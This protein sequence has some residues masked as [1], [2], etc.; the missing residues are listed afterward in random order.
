MINTGASNIEKELS[1]KGIVLIDDINSTNKEL[2][3]NII[4]NCDLYI[5][6]GFPKPSTNAAIVIKL[7]TTMSKINTLLEETKNTRPDIFLS[8]T[9]FNNFKQKVNFWNTGLFKD[10]IEKLDS[11]TPNINVVINNKIK[12]HDWVYINVLKKLGVNFLVIS[13]KEPFMQNAEIDKEI[14]YKT[15]ENI[16]YVVRD[17]ENNEYTKREIISAKEFKSIDD[18]ESALYDKNETVKVIVSGIGNYNDTCNFYGRLHI[19][20]DKNSRRYKLY[21]G[22]LYSI[23]PDETD[24]IPRVANMNSSYLLKTIP[25]FVSTDIPNRDII[26]KNIQK[27]F[28]KENISGTVLYSKLVYT[29]CEINKLLEDKEISVIV[30]YGK[31]SN[32]EKEVLSIINVIDALS[33]IV[34]CPDKSINIDVEGIQK[35]ELNN[36]VEFFE[37]PLIDRRIGINTLAA[38]AENI[39]NNTLFNG[40]TLGM[41]KQGQFT[42]CRVIDFNT[43]YDE[44]KLWWN[45]EVYLRPGFEANGNTATIPTIFRVIK[46]CSTSAYNYMVEI[47]KYCCGK[48]LLCSDKIALDR[49]INPERVCNIV[50][51]T[52]V[53]N[54]KYND[55]KPFFK[56][57]EI[58]KD[59]IKSCKNYYYTF[60]D[61]NKQNLILNKIEDILKGEKINKGLYKTEQEFIDD[62]LNVGLNLDMSIL[63]HIQWFEFYTYNPNL[64]LIL[65]DKNLYNNQNML[66]KQNMILLALLQSLGFDILIFVPTSYQS[67][68][69]L[70]GKQFVYDINIIGEANYNISTLDT[71][72][73]VVTNNI[74]IKG[75]DKKPKKQGFF[76]KLLGN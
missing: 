5:T 65:P 62:V 59:R 31:I 37:M 63:Q 44:I 38:N 50:N 45:K 10:I 30:V 76:S 15:S 41:Y 32:Q 60:M 54:T 2:V 6:D 40:D 22:K 42:D 55:R 57:G 73:L 66:D 18:I 36:T 29:V 39:T 7:S 11:N 53:N 49:L 58:N 70:V 51:G 61:I 33:I 47:Q 19:E 24:R 74:E 27:H 20:C 64:V 46:G 23:T 56:N 72:G 1:I 67:I 14:T 71:Y 9:Q 48:T 34:A 52:D 3:F 35:I 17:I 28:G 4:D 16:E 26:I 43:T 12:K 25:N 69:S 21:Q 13:T 8:E 68:E 75:I